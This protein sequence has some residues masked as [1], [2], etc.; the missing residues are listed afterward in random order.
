MHVVTKKDILIA[1]ACSNKHAPQEVV[2]D[3]IY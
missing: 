3:K 2:R 1:L